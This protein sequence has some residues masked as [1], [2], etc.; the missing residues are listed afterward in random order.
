[1]SV[2]SL[3]DLRAAFDTVDD[4]VLSCRLK[5]LFQHQSKCTFIV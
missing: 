4:N 5:N 2:L 1:M 3:L